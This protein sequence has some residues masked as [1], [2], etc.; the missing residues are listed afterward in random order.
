MQNRALT[1]LVANLSRIGSV[2]TRV[3]SGKFLARLKVSDD[4]L[5]ND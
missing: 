2:K 1:G 4:F 3:V 5:K